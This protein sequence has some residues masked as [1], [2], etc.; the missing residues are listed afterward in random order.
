MEPAEAFLERS[1]Q[2]P[3]ATWISSVSSIPTATGPVSSRADSPTAAPPRRRETRSRSAAVPCFGW[4]RPLQP[5]AAGAAAGGGAG[6]RG[7][8]DAKSMSDSVTAATDLE[9]GLALVTRHV[10][11]FAG[12]HVKLINPWEVRVNSSMSKPL[13]IEFPRQHPTRDLPRRQT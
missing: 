10:S 9:H 6:R 13:C 3:S 1:G 11:D 4:P 2:R 5:A 8:P 7:V 12:I